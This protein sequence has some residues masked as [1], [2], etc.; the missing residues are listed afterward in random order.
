MW[1]KWQLRDVKYSRFNLLSTRKIQKKNLLQIRRSWSSSKRVNHNL[2]P[3]TLKI[4]MIAA[5][6]ATVVK[7]LIPQTKR[8]LIPWMNT[9][10][11]QLLGN[12][13]TYRIAGKYF[14]HMRIL[15]RFKWHRSRASMQCAFILT[16]R[17]NWMKECMCQECSFSNSTYKRNFN[18]RS[19]Q[20]WICLLQSV[21]LS[22]HL[23][24]SSAVDIY[25]TLH[26][27]LSENTR[28]MKRNYL[29]RSR[30]NYYKK[31]GHINI[32]IIYL[33]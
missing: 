16:V 32:P 3:I 4:R 25:S 6:A 27:S 11:W 17:N 19:N 31:N 20:Q 23:C 26:R 33:K 18:W 30:N 22:L 29:K 9:L 24:F 28:N 1:R 8:I 15:Q 10:C 7:V 21:L 13:F 12:R 14:F 5:A 2:L